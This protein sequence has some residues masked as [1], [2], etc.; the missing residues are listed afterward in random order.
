MNR[1]FGIALFFIF[2]STTVRSQYIVSSYTWFTGHDFM[3]IEICKIP[4][5][6]WTSDCRTWDLAN[7]CSSPMVIKPEVK[8]SLFFEEEDSKTREIDRRKIQDISRL[9]M[10]EPYSFTEEWYLEPP[11]PHPPG[12]SVYRLQRI[13][14]YLFEAFSGYYVA[15]SDDLD[16]MITRD[17][18]TGMRST[19]G[20]GGMEDDSRHSFLNIFLWTPQLDYIS[21]PS[22]Y[23]F[24]WKKRKY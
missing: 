20:M 9:V 15:D 6:N 19:Y 22:N 1:Y 10:K 3:C 12:K 21:F 14:R 18:A 4:E 16:Y 7:I 2:F 23:D 8:Y 11:H 24:N 13:G 5:W 17:T